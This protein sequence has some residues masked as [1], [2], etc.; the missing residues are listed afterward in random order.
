MWL[1]ECIFPDKST[2]LSYSIWCRRELDF[3]E[4]WIDAASIGCF[5]EAIV[6]LIDLSDVGDDILE[7]NVFNISNIFNTWPVCKVKGHSYIRESSQWSKVGVERVD[8]P[9]VSKIQSY[10]ENGVCHTRRVS[11]YVS[12]FFNSTMSNESFF[13]AVLLINVCDVSGSEDFQEKQNIILQASII[14]ILVILAI[15]ILHASI[16]HHHLRHHQ[17]QQCHQQEVKKIFIIQA[18]TIQRQIC[19]IQMFHSKQR[20][21]EKGRFENQ[22]NS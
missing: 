1:D 14:I 11:L 15:I 10:F 16:H 22:M 4:Y 21:L 2:N 3:D 12:R 19:E 13:C 7:L 18:S 20:S 17:Q 6:T 5:S 8:F 9:Y